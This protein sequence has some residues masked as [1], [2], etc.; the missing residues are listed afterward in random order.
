M[1]GLPLRQRGWEA[2]GLGDERTLS[3]VPSGQTRCV[4]D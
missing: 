1:E 3:T 4:G 2:V